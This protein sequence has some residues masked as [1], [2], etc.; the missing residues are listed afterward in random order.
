M[1]LIAILEQR[2][3]KT[4]A[5]YFIRGFFLS[6]NI[7]SAHSLTLSIE[8]KINMIIRALNFMF[9][10]FLV[11]KETESSARKNLQVK[12]VTNRYRGSSSMHNQ[13]S[14]FLLKFSNKKGHVKIKKK[15]NK[16]KT[17]RS[18][19][20]DRVSITKDFKP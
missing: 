18:K 20:R 11:A 17:I 13:V 6:R 5:C 2:V 14:V 9:V 7:I 10:K 1:G 12:R 8:M 3:H 19:Y 15:C 16:R 4:L